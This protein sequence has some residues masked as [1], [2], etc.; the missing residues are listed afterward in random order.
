MNVEIDL[1]D[2]TKFSFPTQSDP[3][4][5]SNLSNWTESL[6]LVTRL[7]D[8]TEDLKDPEAFKKHGLDLA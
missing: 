5:Y 1:S 8:G 2:L 6:S 4:D 7:Q 3:R